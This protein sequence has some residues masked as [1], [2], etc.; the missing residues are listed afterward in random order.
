MKLRVAAA[1]LFLS[2][3]G[4]DAAG[5]GPASEPAPNEGAGAPSPGEPSSSAGG[6]SLP[7]PLGAP[8]PIV[9]MHGMGGFG[10]LEV[11]PIEVTYFDGVVDDLVKRGESVFV[12]LAPP[13]E[14]SEVRA[15]AVAKQ[16]DTILKNTGK[17]KVNLVGHSQGGLDARV[18]ASPNGL[19]YGDRI[20]S[21][22]T[23]ATP[24]RGS[25]VADAVLGSLS[26]LP[27][28]VVDQ[29]TSD[30]L[31][32]VQRT[33]YEL[34]TDPK[35]RAQLTMLSERY[36]TDVFNPKY[37]DDPNVLYMSYGGRTNMRTGILACA[38]AVYPNDPTDVD[39]PQA[40]L[41]AT[42]WFLEEGRL[43]V[44]DGMVTVASSKWGVFQQCVPADHLKEVGQLGPA[45]A[46]FDH[47]AFFRT[48]VERIRAAG[49]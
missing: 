12:T 4:T 10:K 19:A 13:F 40:S 11:G 26:G 36:M 2:A 15:E 41:A 17:A 9:L 43:E 37:V 7:A 45:A 6:D 28:S 5:I 25:R 46:T 22:T 21:V 34:D 20:A 39:V 44:N 33:A 32:I 47:L 49:L 24:H 18:L 42:A 35:L 48:I 14:T 16:I 3:C 27:P 30:F 38:D 1:L 8:Y 31:S 23:I 29:I